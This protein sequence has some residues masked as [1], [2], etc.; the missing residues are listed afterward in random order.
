MSRGY[1]NK[2]IILAGYQ[3]LCDLFILG[4]TYYIWGGR[5]GPIWSEGPGQSRNPLRGNDLRRFFGWLAKCL[6]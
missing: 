5:T 3:V 1:F 2:N 6:D 4:K